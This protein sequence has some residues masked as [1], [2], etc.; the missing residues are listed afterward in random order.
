MQQGI[1]ISYR[2]DGSSTFAGILYHELCRFFAA[3]NVFKDVHALQ[4]GSDFKQSINTAIENTAV[5]LVLIDKHWAQMRKPDAP[6]ETVRT[7][8]TA[9]R[10]FDKNDFV[11]HEIKTA[12]QKKIEI[13]PVLFENGEM[14]QKNNCLPIYECCAVNTHSPSTQK[15]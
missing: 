15:P 11:R 14:L 2:R 13:I 6:A 3:E 12:L 9:L 10:I 8:T 5:F 7:S 1:F 4:P